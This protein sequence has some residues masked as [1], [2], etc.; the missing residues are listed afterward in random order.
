MN[1]AGQREVHRLAIQAELDAG[2]S[3]HDRNRLG[4][5]ATPTILARE[6]V[7][8]GIQLLPT[9]ARVRFLDPAF[10]TGSFYSALL[11]IV[12]A[13]RIQSA[14]GF[15]I[16][17][18]YGAPARKFWEEKSLNLELADF[19]HAHPPREKANF[20]ICN[21]PYV[22]H[23]HVDGGDKQR[24]QS[25]CFRASGMRLSGLAGL[26][27][28]FLGLSHEWMA[29]GGIA[30]WLIPSEFMDVNYGKAVKEYLLREVTLLRIHRFDPS[31]VQF[32]DALVSSAVVWF[33]KSP[34]PPG[35]RVEFTFGG[36][37]ASPAKSRTVSLDVLS[38]EPKWTRFPLQASRSG[39]TVSTLGDLFD[40]KRG[41]ATGSNEYFMLTAERI[42]ELELPREFCRPILPS[43]RFLEAD[44]ITADKDGNPILAKPLFLLDCRLPEEE[45]KARYPRLWAYYERGRDE[46]RQRYLCKTRS[47]WY[48]QENRLP[49]PFLCTYMGRGNKESRQPFRFILNHSSAIVANSYLVLYPKAHLTEQL[50]H[51]SSLTRKLWQALNSISADTLTDEGRVYGG[52]LHKMEPKELAN[53]SAE[54]ILKIARVPTQPDLFTLHTKAHPHLPA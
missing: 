52:G 49:S 17:D 18:H 25:R 16:D 42:A 21:P 39:E 34:P 40:I 36:T 5:F 6:V 54:R 48:A 28:Y 8:H 47:P 12:P 7:A 19:T 30:G 31:D 15:E 46:M 1:Q 32:D 38:S 10:G 20:L 51:D 44:E 13:R 9:D 29:E 35:H 3:K 22:R 37:H 14:S 45:V 33:K 24:L 41:I 2:K 50:R 53:V 27:C 23:H 26:Y 4:Q 43:P 11:D